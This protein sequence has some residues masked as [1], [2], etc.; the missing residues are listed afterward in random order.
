MTRKHDREEAEFDSLD[1]ALRERFQ[2]QAPAT[3]DRDDANAIWDAMRAEL[4]C[5]VPKVEQ[6][7]KAI[8]LPNKSYWNFG[9]MLTLA[10]ACC[11]IAF[12]SIFMVA[13][14]QRSDGTVLTSTTHVERMIARQQTHRPT[15]NQWLPEERELWTELMRQTASNI[16]PDSTVVVALSLQKK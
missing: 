11:L 3:T 5:E 8:S 1:A 4:Q 13:A 15:N 12:S 2:Q 14:K 9:S 6:V 10:A 16:D 7:N